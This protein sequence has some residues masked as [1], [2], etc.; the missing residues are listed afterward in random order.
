MKSGGVIVASWDAT[1]SLMSRLSGK[2]RG[3]ANFS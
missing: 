2:Q 1:F 3:Y